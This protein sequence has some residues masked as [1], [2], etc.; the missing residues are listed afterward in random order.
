MRTCKTPR[1]KVRSRVINNGNYFVS[2][3]VPAYC[4]K[5]YNGREKLGGRPRTFKIFY[6]SRTIQ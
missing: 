5:K 6:K 2:N 3:I 4:E 1:K